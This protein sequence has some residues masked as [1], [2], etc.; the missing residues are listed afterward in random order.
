MQLKN[1][2]F[3]FLRVLAKC[4]VNGNPN[5]VKGSHVE[6]FLERNKNLEIR[7]F[8]N[9]ECSATVW[10]ER[11]VSSEKNIKCNAFAFWKVSKDLRKK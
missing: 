6:R 8:K 5:Y 11:G 9:P 4:L 7:R 1:I 3:S 2:D 10:R